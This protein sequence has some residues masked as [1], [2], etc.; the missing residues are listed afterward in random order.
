MRLLAVE[1]AGTSLTLAK[2]YKWHVTMLKLRGHVA[3]FARA[4]AVQFRSSKAGQ[5][6]AEGSKLV[7]ETMAA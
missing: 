3:R 2:A 5:D 7:Q 4:A 1:A 6:A